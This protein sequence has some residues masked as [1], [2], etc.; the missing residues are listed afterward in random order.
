MSTQ[1]CDGV[2][3]ASC[4]SFPHLIFNRIGRGREDLSVQPVT[5]GRD[6]QIGANGGAGTPGVTASAFFECRKINS[7]WG[8]PST[9]AI[10][11]A[12]LQND[13]LIAIRNP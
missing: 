2:A 6:F 13:F 12:K 11:G 10:A 9:R 8:I 7:T 5:V 4:E 3:A 1:G